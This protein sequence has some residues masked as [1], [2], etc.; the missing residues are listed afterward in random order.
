MG[1]SRSSFNVLNQRQKLKT[2]MT[3]TED[4]ENAP[5]SIFG[6]VTPPR[7]R[8]TDLL[9][10]CFSPD[11][12]WTM[13]FRKPYKPEDSSSGEGNVQIVSG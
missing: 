10:L 5:L 11:A 13:T 6:E 7:Q 9:K 8:I 1:T 3:H 2:S 4:N 12:E